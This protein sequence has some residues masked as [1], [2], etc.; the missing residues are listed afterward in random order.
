MFFVMSLCFNFYFVRN[1]YVIWAAWFLYAMI[2]KFFF[3]ASV[4]KVF[5]YS[6]K[7]TELFL[8]P[9]PGQQHEVAAPELRIRTAWRFKPAS[10]TINQKTLTL[11][12]QKWSTTRRECST[13][14]R[15]GASKTA[16]W[17]E[18]KPPWPFSMAM[19]SCVSSPIP[20]RRWLVSETW[21]CLCAHQTFI[22]TNSSMLLLLALLITY[23]GSGRCYKIYRKFL[24]ST[25]VAP[26]ALESWPKL[27]LIYLCRDHRLVE[28]ICVQSMLIYVICVAF[29]LRKCHR[30]MIQHW[31]IKKPF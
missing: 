22:T 16:S 14:A 7:L 17:I 25:W 27:T 9:R 12:R 30:T 15:H 24:C 23:A 5:W 26:D 18:T 4:V 3:Q 29:Y 31:L 19:S 1:Q 21:L 6:W 13:G 20:T 8:P 11:K 2:C 28:L 10:L